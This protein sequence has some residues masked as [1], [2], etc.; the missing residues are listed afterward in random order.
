MMDK[1]GS[2]VCNPLEEIRVSLRDVRGEPHVEFRVYGR[3]RSGEPDPLPGREAITLPA[4]LL[5]VFLRV[6][7]QAQE[8]PIKRGVI[9]IP[10]PAEATVLEHGEPVTI[11]LAVPP[12]HRDARQHPRMPLSVPVECRVV[13]PE[14]LLARQTSQRRG[15]GREHRW[16]ASL[17]CEAASAI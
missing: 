1:L 17:A 6:L 7:S 8:I 16:R 11:R 3:S 12:G 15:Q 4:G 10:S 2:M 13:D 14:K 5:P 9:Y